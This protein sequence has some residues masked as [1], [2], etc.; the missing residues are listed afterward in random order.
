MTRDLIR[1][2]RIRAMAATA[3]K[4]EAYIDTASNSLA[5][6]IIC[7]SRV[8]SMRFRMTR[9]VKAVPAFKF[10]SLR[11]AAGITTRPAPFIL[12]T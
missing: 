9:T 5:F 2:F 8:S 12:I 11:I 10:N 7:G 3:L 6:F 1:E 4:R